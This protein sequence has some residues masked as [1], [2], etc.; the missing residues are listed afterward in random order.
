MSEI[1]NKK[2]KKKKIS[3]P[4]KKK[5]SLPCVRDMAQHLRCFILVKDSGQHPHGDSQPSATPVSRESNGL[6]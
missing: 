5:K 4:K 6:F 1:P 2:W 3:I